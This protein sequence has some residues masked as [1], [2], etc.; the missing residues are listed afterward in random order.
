MLL[1]PVVEVVVV[2]FVVVVVVFVVVA[3][4]VAAAVEEEEDA[5]DEKEK[6]V[7]EDVDEA[8]VNLDVGV[9]VGDFPAVKK[10]AAKGLDAGRELEE[11]VVAVALVLV[12]EEDA[13]ALEAK[14]SC[15]G[16]IAMAWKGFELC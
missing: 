6:G 5:D 8:N 13:G 10:V 3:A 14:A 15:E 16:A 1:N 7:P 4:V 11:G 9:K 12:L 2:V